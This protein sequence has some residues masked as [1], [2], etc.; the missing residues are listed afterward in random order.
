M[1]EIEISKEEE[2]V[3]NNVVASLRFENQIVTEEEKEDWL[4]VMR[5][6]ITYEEY[7]NKVI[8]KLADQRKS[9]GI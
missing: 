1:G 4:K 3:I 2:R 9:R 7:K 5:G 8:S 6:Q